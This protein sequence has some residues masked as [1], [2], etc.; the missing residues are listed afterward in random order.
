VV[1]VLPAVE[2]G[3]VVEV[4]GVELGATVVLTEVEAGALLAPPLLLPEPEPM[5]VVIEPLS[6]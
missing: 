4:T 6:M 2:E 5:A 3:A 1:P